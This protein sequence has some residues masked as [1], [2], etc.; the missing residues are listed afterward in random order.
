MERD[1]LEADVRSIS[2]EAAA[3]RQQL[4]TEVQAVQALDAEAHSLQSKL[5]AA[6][7]L[8]AAKVRMSYSPQGGP[9][10]LLDQDGHTPV[11]ILSA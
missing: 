1:R 2:S 3:L 6:Q 10:F 4:S 8:L 7:R 9:T 11:V 5:A